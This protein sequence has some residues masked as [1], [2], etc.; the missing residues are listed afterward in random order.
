[1][2]QD[3][4]THNSHAPAS[5]YRLRF[6]VCVFLFVLA[7]FG[8]FINDA[9]ESGI[10]LLACAAFLF[11]GFLIWKNAWRGLKKL[12]ITE[13]LLVTCGVLAGYIYSVSY[14]IFPLKPFGG[15][16]SLLLEGMF[17]LAVANYA[18]MHESEEKEKTDSFLGRIEEF[19][20]KSARLIENKKETKIFAS[21]IKEGM[22]LLVKAGERI[23]CDAV[24]KKGKTE[25]DESLISGNTINAYRAA[26]DKVYGATLNK[27]QD[28]LI[29][30]SA[31]LKKSEFMGIINAIKTGEKE[32]AAFASEAPV[33]GKYAATALGAAIFIIWFCVLAEAGFKN[34]LYHAQ[35][36]LFFIF[37]AAPPALFTARALSGHFVKAGA[38]LKKIKISNTDTLRI[39]NKAQDCY[40]D[41]TGTITYGALKVNEVFPVKKITVKKLLAAALS[42]EYTLNSPFADAL[43]NYCKGKAVKPA[44]TY[45]VEVLPGKGVISKTK[46]SIIIVGDRKF[47]H[48]QG[49]DSPD[50]KGAWEHDV[51]TGVALNGEF[52]GYITFFDS[53][54]PHAYETMDSL[55]ASG[56]KIYLL[57]GD[58]EKTVSWIAKESG[59][60]NYYAG[61]LPEEKAA[62][63]RKSRA[64]GKI[65]AMAGDGFNDILALLRADVS[66]VFAK[67]D[68]LHANWADIVIKNTD[69]KSLLFIAKAYKTMRFNIAENIIIAFI[70]SGLLAAYAYFGTYGDAPWFL[71]LGFM[72]AGM[73]AVTLNSMR[74][75]KI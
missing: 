32:K 1:M 37:F 54:K 12:K 48:E 43:R 28:I 3:K 11:G 20:P 75:I 42:A 26:G 70:F 45:S 30:C 33:Y 73:L 46:S 60:A 25:I 56:K 49:T 65:T 74:L 50:M 9:A 36:L 68:T 47:L 40:I 53:L 52:L 38:R 51:I 55:T 5:S 18:R 69:V 71:C 19:I 14:M 61:V 27:V 58:N 8:R 24:I 17:L 4:H 21:E 31:P 59:I 39:F 2:T 41:K 63:I 57:S 23:P 10:L 15:I 44:K 64:E 7:A 16:N 29:E 6:F 67:K 66:I 62:Y 72:T 35:V 34:I 13:D 22:V